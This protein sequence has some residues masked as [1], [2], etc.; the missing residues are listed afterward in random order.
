MNKV[1]RMLARKFVL[2]KPFEGFPKLTDFQIVEETLPAELQD[3][4]I[5]IHLH[6][7]SHSR[8]KL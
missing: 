5:C 2:A 1:S 8:K 6:C 4:G 3:G 7:R